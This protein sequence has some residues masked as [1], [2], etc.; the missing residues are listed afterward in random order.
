[1][2]AQGP[3]HRSEP[4]TDP[5]FA[6]RAVLDTYEKSGAGRLG[7]T[8]LGAVHY[9][10]DL[11]NLGLTAPNPRRDMIV[12]TIS[13]LPLSAADF[14]CDGK[15]FRRAAMPAGGFALQDHRRQ[16]HTVVDDPF[17]MIDLFLPVAVFD[18]WT[19][20]I[21]SPRVD[22]LSLPVTEAHC[23][24]TMFHIAMSLMPALRTP[25]EASPLF[26]D[27]LFEAITV[28]LGITYASLPRQLERFRGGLAPW[29]YKRARDLM[30]EN[31]ANCPSLTQLAGA[32]GL[33]NRHFL[34]AF[35]T[36]NGLSPHRWLLRARVQRARELLEK[37]AEPI[38]D[39]AH[40][41]GFADQSHLTR[42]FGNLVGASPAAWRRDRAC[43][44]GQ[45][46]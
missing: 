34:R 37:S 31:L 1:M 46:R 25:K 8:P 15:S 36:T 43:R 42:T 23:D 5:Y 2:A 11:P 16:F 27:H 22:E 10:R 29:Q 40:A 18:R 3:D 45:Y 28:H 44:A 21:G 20:E 33:S 4:V 12:A 13:L 14:W 35:K 17:E 38:A 41:C 30:L 26:L 32:C 39:I 19:D 7:Q 24:A 9:K 6:D